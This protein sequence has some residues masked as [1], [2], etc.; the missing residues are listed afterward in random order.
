M[1]NALPEGGEVLGVSHWRVER[2]LPWYVDIEAGAFDGPTLLR[3]TRP[4]EKVA[5]VMTVQGEA[6]N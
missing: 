3:G 6:E 4:R 2:T 1:S 5:A